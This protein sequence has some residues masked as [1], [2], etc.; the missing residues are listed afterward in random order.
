MISKPVPAN[1]FYHT[2]RYICQKKG[3]EV[4]IVEGVRSHNFKVMAEDFVRQQQ[5]RPTKKMACLHSI[6]SFHPNE[7]PSDKIMKEIAAKY[8]QRLNIINTQFAISK[9]TDKAHLHLHIVANMVNNDGKAISDSWIGLRGK[10][11]AQQLTQ[12]YGLMPAVK[13]DMSL[14][15]VEAMSQHEANKYKIYIAISENLPYCSTMEELEKRLLRHGIETKYKY[16]GQTLEKQGISFKIDDGCFKGSSV[17]RKFSLRSLER[18][19]ELQREL[20]L[21]QR[22]KMDQQHV[23][24]QQQVSKKVKNQENPNTS[25]GQVLQKEINNAFEILLQHEQVNDHLPYELLR[26]NKRKR[27][28]SR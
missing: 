27:K 16:K 8:L 9:H 10:N 1:S 24:P 4:L 19:L 3:A 25:S 28:R 22:I 13:K 21:Q 17:D 20:L 15:H 26:K 6:L 7:K 14:T 5:L 23:H 2:C 18:T 12:E 11:I